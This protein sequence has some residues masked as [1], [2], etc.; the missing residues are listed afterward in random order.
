MMSNFKISSSLSVTLQINM[1]VTNIGV[2]QLTPLNYW[3]A[4][5]NG[6]KRRTFLAHLANVS[7][8]ISFLK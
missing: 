8:Y 6:P 3:P 4:K 1:F 2:E 7:F 5:K